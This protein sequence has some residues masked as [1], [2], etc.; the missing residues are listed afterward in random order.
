MKI[1]DFIK[2]HK[3]LMALIAA[4]AIIG[5]YFLVVALT[6][7][8]SSNTQYQTARAK[9]GTITKTVSGSGQIE[10]VNQV[11]ITAGTS[12]EVSKI[13]VGENE[14]VTE[15]ELLFQLDTA[16]Y[17]RTIQSAQIDLEKAQLQL[18]TLQNAP[19]ASKILAA[20]DAVTKA[21]N[22]LAALKLKQKQDRAAADD[23]K[24]SAQ[25][26]LDALSK[27][28]PNYDTLYDKYTTQLTTANQTLED[29][30]KTGPA[31]ISQ[32]NATIKE[33]QAVLD[34]LKAGATDEEIRSQQL[35]VE[36]AQNDLSTVQAKAKDY[37][38]RAPFS[39]VITAVNVKVGDSV[40]G[41]GSSSASTTTGTSTGSSSSSTTSSTTSSASSSSSQ[42][43][44]TLVTGHKQAAITINEVDRPS[45][46]IGQKAKLTF[47]AITD[48]TLDGTVTQIDADGAAS[49]GVV[50]YGVTVALDDQNNQIQNGMSVSAE[51]TVGESDK[52]IVIS[53]AAIKSRDSGQKYVEV[54]DSQASTTPR[55]VTV[56][57]GLTND[58]ESEITSGLKAGDLV[59]TSETSAATSTSGS[60]TTNSTTNSTSRNRNSL[61]PFGGGGGF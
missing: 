1:I 46:K 51:I 49:S 18:E 43:M 10:D 20:Q 41:G 29:L 44:A 53:S 39:G 35:A 24:E 61:T 34:E 37:Q 12:G 60:S 23:S 42:G 17:N 59:V 9:E 26:H 55:Q 38:V 45:L 50:S 33:K 7:A 11:T 22:D 5:G 30:D 15:N 27:S 16:D 48:L 2:T 31:D 54:M 25:D 57:V 52:T 14:A 8:P 4:G 58:T 3:I 28:D 6:A 40:S 13:Y 47:D 21:Q 19:D 32:A 56:E 36:K